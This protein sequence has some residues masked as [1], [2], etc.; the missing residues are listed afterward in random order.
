MGPV[1]TLGQQKQGMVGVT[2]RAANL[3]GVRASGLKSSKS[4]GNW[5]KL[6]ALAGESADGGKVAR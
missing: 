1:H 5:D 3:V 2:G 6:G 4:W